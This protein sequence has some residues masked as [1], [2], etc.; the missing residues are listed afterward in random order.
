MATNDY[1]GCELARSFGFGIMTRVLIIRDKS[2]DT[3]TYR[4][5]KPICVTVID[6]GILI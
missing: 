5:V 3:F 4:S 2:L 1:G 6:N